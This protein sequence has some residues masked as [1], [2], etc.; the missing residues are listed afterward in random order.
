[1]TKLSAMPGSTLDPADW[2]E[3]RAQAH[4]MLDDMLD[5][6]KHLRDQP[7]WQP[8]PES[9]RAQFRKALPR[10][11]Q[12]LEDIHGEFM[13]SI[14]PYG[15]GNI[16]PRF[17]GWV[18]GGGTVPGMLAEMLAG[19][20]N[21]NLGGRDHSG[22]EVER[23]LVQ[24]VRE[25]FAFPQG[26]SGVFVTGTSMANF[27]AVLVARSFALGDIVG[28]AGLGSEGARLRGYASTA[29]HGCV[30]RAFDFAGL[31]G[32][33]LRDIPVDTLQKMDLAALKARIRRDRKEGLRPFIVIGSAGTVDVGAIDALDAV[34]AFCAEEGLWFH[35]D[36]AYGALGVLSSE[37]APRLKGIERADSIA[38]DFHKWGQA[39]YD[40]GFLLVRD[41]DLHR[42]TFASPAAY[43]SRDSRGLSANSPWPCDFG[44]DLSRGFRALKTWFTLKSFGTEGLANMMEKS[45]ALARQL[46]RRVRKEAELELISGAQLNIV[47]F[48]YRAEQA[49][50]LNRDIVADIQEA[51]IAAP[52]STVVN[53]CVAIRACF[54]NHRTQS[55]DVDALVSSVLDF[56]RQRR[57]RQSTLPARRDIECAAALRN[58]TAD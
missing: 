14:L 50:Q 30:R 15:G 26:A 40:A 28:R 36:G 23:Q 35:V 42:R 4:R 47:C 27:M 19:G 17:M 29:A 56:G 45:C 1:M 6:L 32:D 34:A 53:G 39:P 8:M 21:A 2:D 43:L 13:A 57:K 24:W 38:F 52:S 46:E 25:M 16:H 44:P 31:G 3:T 37:L 9:Q 33:S 41:G 55:S 20:L 54:I 18:Q 10:F 48:R 58:S 22:I 5:H 51:G 7:V 12:P 11:G 49:D